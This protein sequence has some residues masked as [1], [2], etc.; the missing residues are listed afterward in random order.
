MAKGDVA[1]TARRAGLQR[2]GTGAQPLPSALLRANQ[3]GSDARGKSS[4][5]MGLVDGH[6][7]SKKLRAKF[8]EIVGAEPGN[9]RELAEGSGVKQWADARQQVI[10]QGREDGLTERDRAVARMLAPIDAQF[11]SAVRARLDDMRAGLD[12]RAADLP[13]VPPLGEDAALPPPD[14][15]EQ[16]RLVRERVRDDYAQWSEHAAVAVRTNDR[17]LAAELVSVGRRNTLPGGPWFKGAVYN[18]AQNLVG[19]MQEYFRTPKVAA[20]EVNAVLTD[21]QR[22]NLGALETALNAPDVAQQLPLLLFNRAFAWLQAPDPAQDPADRYD[23]ILAL[24]VRAGERLQELDE[25]GERLI[26]HDSEAPGPVQVT[27]DWG[28]PQL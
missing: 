2:L 14:R 11:Q 27:G 5:G 7:G 21:L 1:P 22:A 8:L 10:T 12:Q 9:G 19:T 20:G 17:A 15:A 28:G 4:T 18:T 26:G 3:L 16:L 6:P 25:S 13:V 24:T 23:A